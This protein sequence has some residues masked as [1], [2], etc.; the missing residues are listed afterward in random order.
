MSTTRFALHRPEFFDSL[1]RGEE[2]IITLMRGSELQRNA[3][4]PLIDGGTDHPYVY[5]LLR[6]WAGRV[7]T[8]PDG[9]AQFILIFLPSDLFGIKSLFVSRHVD[10]IRA[11]SDIVVERVHYET[12][13]ELYRKDSDVSVRCTWQVIEEERRLH[14]WVV[15]LGQGSADER[16]AW[17]LL[18]FKG[19]LQSCGL[20]AR[21]ALSY[22]MPL[23]QTQLADHMGITSVHMNRVLREFRDNGIVTVRNGQVQ[24]SDLESLVQRAAPLLDIYE[25]NNEAYVGNHPPGGSPPR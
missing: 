19:R 18:D 23:T 14:S 21:G 6:G 4:R 11:I 12:L 3:G 16:L 15:G 10:S 1:A 9:R 22:D 24:I 2:K 7:R 20:L 8:L 5:R 17:L 25:R 13:Y